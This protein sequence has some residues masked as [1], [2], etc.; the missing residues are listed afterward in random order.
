[1]YKNS[2]INDLQIIEIED[3]LSE[4]EVDEILTPRK[5][6]FEKASTHYPNYYRNNDRLVEDNEVLATKLFNKLKQIG[7]PNMKSERSFLAI[8]D[9]IR[10]CRY[11]KGQLFSKHQDGVYY[12]NTEQETKYTVLLYLNDHASFDAGETEFYNQKTD[13]IPQKTI[14]PKKGKL[15]IFDH[16]IWHKGAK[17]TQGNKYILR[18]DIIVK[19]KKQNTNHDGYI[20]NLLPI[21]KEQFLSCG[22]DR[23]I[24]CWDAH[25][26]CKHIIEVHSNSVLKII[27]LN[28]D[29]FISCSRD[30]S[31]KKWNMSGKVLSHIHLNE[32]ILNIKTL[33]NNQII[34]TG[35]SGKIYVLSTNLEIIKTIKVHTNWVWGLAIMENDDFISCCEH[36]S[37]H[38]TN[39]I[40]EKT[41]C[42]Y[43]HDQP[44][45]CINTEKKDVILIGSKDGT[46]IQLSRNTKK[47]LKYKVHSDI[48]RSIVCH[49]DHIYTCGEDNKVVSINTKTKKST[50]LMVADNF[51]TDLIILKDQLYCSGYD[52]NI[53][54]RKI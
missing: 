29:E 44:L 19:R 43:K 52:G 49:K 34:A 54:I 13:D 50:D 48:I 42:I 51:M 10:F 28:Q 32:M 11:Q 24:K 23:K 45:F 36:G 12:P 5:L 39:V 27:Q 17:V 14:I 7:I 3:F 22:R 4:K 25:L 2:V 18:S 26:E 20:W 16:Q 31:I 9:R 1:M 47:I 35:T 33:K 21:T 41:E 30:F 37:V 46:L 38:I 15:V 40:S 8:N 53:A 6:L